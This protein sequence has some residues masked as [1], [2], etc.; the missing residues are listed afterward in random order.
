[1]TGGRYPLTD[2]GCLEMFGNT[3]FEVWDGRR[4][5]VL[6]LLSGSEGICLTVCVTSQIYVHCLVTEKKK[7]AKLQRLE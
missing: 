7:V 1:M 6:V 2:I 4:R 5:G 3:D